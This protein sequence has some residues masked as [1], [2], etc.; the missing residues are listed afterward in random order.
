MP[1]RP[2]PT[3]F[4]SLQLAS[5]QLTKSL[6]TFR[7]DVTGANGFGVPEDAVR[8]PGTL[9]LTLGVMSLKQEGVSQA[10]DL[11]NSLKPREILSQ[12]RAAAGSVPS[13]NSSPS[14]STTGGLSIS[15]RGLHSMTSASKTSVLYAP[16]TDA[17]GILYKFCEE[18]RQPFREKGLMEDDGRPLLLHATIVNTIYVRGRGG[19]RRK[20]RLMLDARDLM[21]KYEDYVWVEDMPV[22]MVA[23]CKMGAKKVDGD[24]V[25]DVE[26]EIEI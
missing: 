1:P 2:N 3:H 9:H 4:L 26:G 25:Y 14:G 7:A 13:T 21:S 18:L 23:V 20:E 10:V 5:A 16:P 12:L 11:L 15:L 6:A 24:E 22:C 19:A 17:E 8:P